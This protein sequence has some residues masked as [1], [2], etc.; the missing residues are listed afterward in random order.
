MESLI[1][2]IFQEGQAYG[3]L[4]IIAVITAIIYVIL[5]A[6][7]NRWCFLYGLIS[8]LIYIYLATSLKFYFDTAINMYYVFM[9]F[10]GW[11]SWSKATKKDPLAI[12]SMPKKQ[13]SLLITSAGLLTISLAYFADKIS[14]ASLPYIDAFTTVFAI[15]ATWM[16]VK[17]HAE[18]WLIWIV[19]DSIA[20]AMYFYK[21]LFLTSLLF[22]FYTVIS[23]LGYQKWKRQVV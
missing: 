3:S 10:Y 1:D 20:A 23:I 17:R 18:S 2:S 15:L 12:I 21:G 19:V 8:S 14:D 11:L 9:S 4:E 16:I 6:K 22:I 13:L 5:A 7:A